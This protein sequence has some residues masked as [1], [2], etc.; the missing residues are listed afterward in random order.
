MKTQFDKIYVITLIS[1]KDRQE[2]IKYQMNEL[3]L[4][5]E[6]IYGTDFYNLTHDRYGNNINYPNL[7][8]ECPHLDNIKMYGCTLSHYQA[9]LQSY[10]FGY[11]N[12]LIIEDDM[13]FNKDLNLVEYYLNNIPADID[14]ITYTARFI[15]IEE[16]N[17]FNKI[18]R[19]NKK[20]NN[21]FIN[22]ENLNG[23]CG[24]GMYGIV[25]RETMKLYLDNQRAKLSCADHINGIFK[26][27]IINRCTTLYAICTDQF[28]LQKQ[29]N[30]NQNDYEW[31]IFCYQQF[32]IIKSFNNFYTPQIYH[33][34]NINTVLENF[35]K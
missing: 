5:F 24:T 7:I 27:P 30:L 20:V 4:D 1:N 25:N 29:N 23:L 15:N 14:F 17:Q 12:V 19:G 8:F 6:F 11:N 21:K 26:K 34:S 35:I 3:G 13:C 9:I 31:G 10:E 2:F 32:N 16:I 22:L 33:Y 28:N 18:L